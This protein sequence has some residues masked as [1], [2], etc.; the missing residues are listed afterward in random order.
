MSHA[1]DG[2]PPVPPKGHSLN[3][4]LVASFM[5]CM[6][7]LLLFVLLTLVPR[8]STMLATNAIERTKETVLQS[9][10][11]V[12]I[13]VDNMLSTLYFTTTIL[14]ASMDEDD[15]AW[16]ARMEL[17]KKSNSSI[18]SLAFF[19][20]N[21]NLF[22]STAG[23]LQV[24]PAQVAREEWFQKTLSWGGT[25][26]YFSMPHVQNLFGGQYAYVITLARAVHYLSG[27]KLTRGVVLM[28]IDYSSLNE[29][30]ESISLGPSGYIYILDRA[31]QLVTHPRLQLIYNGLAVEDRTAVNEFL[32]GQGRDQVDGR[33]RVLI[34][35]TLNQTRWRMVGVAYVD[36]IL[37]LQ[38]T[39]IRTISIVLLCA[40]MLS[41]AA[42]SV[43]AYWV[44]RPMRH[45]ENSMR[46]VEA[47]DL[48]AAITESGFREV[49]AVSAAFN[50][51][52]TRIRALMD[53]IVQEQEIKRLYELNA[54][55]A[56]INP[57]FLYNTLDSIIWME[58]RGRSK[59]AIT[60]VS[61]LAKLFRISISKG[62]SVITVREELEHV[63]NYL[64]IQKMRFKDKFTY[65]MDA[66][67]EALGERTVKLIVQ[68][69]VENAINHAIDESQPE[70]LHI[71]ISAKLEG[72]DLLFV[73]EDDGIGISPE[74]LATIL[75]APT[76]RSGIGI[77]NVHERIQLT[78]GEPYG[79]SIQ[80]EEDVGTSVTV[81]L[82]RY[83]G[84]S[85]E[86]G[87]PGAGV[88]H[89]QP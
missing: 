7:V 71:R 80:S 23:Q 45:L 81:R 84:E 46:R 83:Q 26:T 55:Q 4:V 29:L 36:E 41:F 72:A 76:G 40:A 22:G 64:I 67:E 37:E 39:F 47:G 82:P 49:R 15:G 11:G 28:D 25:V 5:T 74:V 19:D 35:A 65:E 87:I 34:S 77:K 70:A 8:L 58:E 17:L 33:E 66:Q 24:T 57:H 43:V 48:N 68:P 73:V 27:G 16:L 86:N 56:Q 10:N 75:T 42:A 53:Q 13:Y 32:V 88:S 3:F 14:P 21:G 52:L 54:L 78:Y 50:H 6:G 38:N 79:L 51:M 12:D 59:E 18:I 63:R 1:A 30:T 69:L 62:R 85:K 61:A 44:T 31:G 60:M 2:F 9:V 89:L 20:E